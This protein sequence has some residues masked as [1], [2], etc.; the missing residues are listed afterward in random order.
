MDSEKETDEIQKLPPYNRLQNMFSE[1]EEPVLTE[2]AND[3]INKLLG[4]EDKPSILDKIK[5]FFQKIDGYIFA[6][7]GKITNKFN[8]RR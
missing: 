4:V 1:G 7:N 3:N 8:S 5:K 6:K 2:K